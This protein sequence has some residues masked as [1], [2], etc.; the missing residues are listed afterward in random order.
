MKRI[1]F[2]V[3]S[4]VM[5]WSCSSD[6]EPRRR[7]DPAQAAAR[8]QEQ[9]DLTDAQ[10]D[11]VKALMEKFRQQIRELREASSG[12]RMEMREVMMEL[13]A[14]QDE[15]IKAVLNDEQKEKYEEIQEERRQNFQRRFRRD[16]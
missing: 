2:S 16:D 1:I 10:R 15:K 14:E 13:R 9:L 12:D 7:L 3:L 4:L 5:L 6:E 8:M 11:T